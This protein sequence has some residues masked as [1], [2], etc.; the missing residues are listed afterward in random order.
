MLDRPFATALWQPFQRYLEERG[1]SIRTGHAAEIISRKDGKWHVEAQSAG[2]TR[3]ISGDL[4]VLALPVPALKSLV[5]GSPDLRHDAFQR[6]VASLE[7]TNPFAVWR[8][9]MDKRVAAERPPFAGTT[10]VGIL[11]NISIY[12]KIE[13]QSRNWSERTGGSVVELHAYAVPR[14]MS[15]DAIKADLLSG[16]HELYPETRGAQ[17]LDD[18]WLLRQDCPAFA[19]GS[20]ALRPGVETPFSGLTLAGDFVKLPMPSALMERATASGF[21]AANHLL[22]PYDVVPEPVFSVPRRGLLRRP[23]FSLRGERHA[24]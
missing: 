18:A 21:M 12:E 16:L 19:P 5:V 1:A 17:I 2:E 13:D 15:E 9:W 11:D 6:S 4:M 3:R 23:T 14:G 7:L 24:A 10:E 22:A 20:H 8:L